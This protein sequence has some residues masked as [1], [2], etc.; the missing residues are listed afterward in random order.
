ML[1]RNDGAMPTIPLGFR[2]LHTIPLNLDD[3]RELVKAIT[4]L[5]SASNPPPIPTLPKPASPLG[6]F[7]AILAVAFAAALGLVVWRLIY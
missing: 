4:R 1:A 5:A 7:D 3:P 6:L 2:S